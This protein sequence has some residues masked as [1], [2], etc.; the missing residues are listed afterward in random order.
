MIGD[1]ADAGDCP[2]PPLS[3]AQNQGAV[4]NMASSI[5][6]GTAEKKGGILVTGKGKR[7]GMYHRPGPAFHDD[8]R[9]VRGCIMIAANQVTSSRIT[10][11]SLFLGAQLWHG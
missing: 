7:A 9:S 6:Q 5:A 11:M 3:I 2:L 10:T 4:M 1:E 8:H